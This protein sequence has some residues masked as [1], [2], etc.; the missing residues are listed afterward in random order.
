MNSL[1]ALEPGDKDSNLVET[2]Y[3]PP[4]RAFSVDLA[5]L[6]TW[7][8]G[9]GAELQLTNEHHGPIT[10]RLSAWAMDQLALAWVLHRA[11][12]I[13]A[14]TSDGHAVD[15]SIARYFDMHAVAEAVASLLHLHCPPS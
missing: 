6:G 9:H 11:Y 14:Y 3:L 2:A 13:I 12:G 1:F 10:I 5:E 7:A 15:H 8:A 4:A